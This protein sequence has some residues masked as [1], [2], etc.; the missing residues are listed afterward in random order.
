MLSRLP[1]ISYLISNIS[2][3]VDNLDEHF[4]RVTLSCSK[5]CFILLG[6]LKEQEFKKGCPREL[7]EH[8]SAIDSLDGVSR[9]AA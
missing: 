5:N 3:H 4:V 1:V 6:S 8:G 9:L 7:V 2:S